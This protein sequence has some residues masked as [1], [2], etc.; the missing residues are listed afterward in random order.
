MSVVRAPVSTMAKV[1]APAFAAGDST[2]AS[3]SQRGS[4]RP[5]LSAIGLSLRNMRITPCGGPLVAPTSAGPIGAGAGVRAAQAPMQSAPKP[6]PSSPHVSRRRAVG[7]NMPTSLCT[8][9]WQSELTLPT[10]R[11]KSLLAKARCW[12]MGLGSGG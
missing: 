11:C 9:A 6:T 12:C 2:R 5:P 1:L 10:D 4:V 8:G 7:P 3:T